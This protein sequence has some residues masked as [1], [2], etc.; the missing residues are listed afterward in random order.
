MKLEKI[1]SDK[2]STIQNLTTELSTVKSQ[3]AEASN[4]RE[5]WIYAGN[6]KKLGLNGFTTNNLLRKKSSAEQ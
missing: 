2:Q 5:H 6:P 1:V 4:P 3:L